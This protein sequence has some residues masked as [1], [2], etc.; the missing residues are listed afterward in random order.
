MTDHKQIKG[1]VGHT[2]KPSPMP[3]VIKRR[4]PVCKQ[5]FDCTDIGQIECL[6]CEATT[7]PAWL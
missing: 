2:V 4:C 1:G 5:L 6:V 7:R 3:S